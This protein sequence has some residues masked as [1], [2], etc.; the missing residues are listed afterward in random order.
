MLYR[1][2]I[3]N[4][5]SIRERQILDLTISPNV[6]DPDNRYAEIFPG[7]K[8]RAP[9]VVALY[10]ANASGKTTVLRGLDL[11][12]TFPAF[13]PRQHGGYNFESFNDE[14]S[15]SKPIKLAI[16]LGG[17]TS[18]DLADDENEFRNLEWGVFRYELV[19]CRFDSAGHRVAS[20]SLY[21]KPADAKKWRRVFERDQHGVKGPTKNVRFFPVSGYSKILDKL[22]NNSS[23]IET[24]ASFDHP[25]SRALVAASGRVY[26][27]VRNSLDREL[28]GILANILSMSP[29]MVSSLNVELR[30]VD[31]GLEHLTIEQTQNGPQVMFKHNG[32]KSD[33][34]WTRESEGTRAFIR[35]F[36]LI[37]QSLVQGGVAIIDE[38]DKVLHPMLLPEIVHRFYKSNGQSPDSSQLW[39]GCH[40]ASLLDDLTK[41][42][43]VIC[44]KDNQGRTE[45]FSLMDVGSVR[46]ND[47]LYKKYLSGV[48][49]GVP[50]IG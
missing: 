33:L 35:I 26:N 30:R 14:E 46:R 39:A 13:N 34:H 29:E 12:T 28:D 2:E 6:P 37:E 42:E 11:I 38:I 47:N 24:L 43:V 10:G 36:P 45:I 49:G 3:E 27:N 17:H 21:Q 5:C 18:L 44:E 15:H 48:Y 9:K 22:P 20:E 40:S 19:L 16:E 50:H 8:L 25:A 32:H 41:E 4:F 31:L 23:V 7:S 1:L